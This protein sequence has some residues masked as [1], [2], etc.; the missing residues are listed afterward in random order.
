VP[1][2]TRAFCKEAFYLL[3]NTTFQAKLLN[4]IPTDK[5]NLCRKHLK[6]NNQLF[7]FNSHFGFL[8][9][10][11]L[12]SSPLGRAAERAAPPAAGEDGSQHPSP[13]QPAGGLHCPVLL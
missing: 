6:Q 9:G 8:S 12:P 11:A 4:F 7:L 10:T 1:R 5:Q 13:A 3:T 2:Q